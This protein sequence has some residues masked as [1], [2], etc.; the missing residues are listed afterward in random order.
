MLFTIRQS[1]EKCREQHGDLYII[2][3]DLMKAFNS[4]NRQGLWSIL[5]KI[6]CLGK[7]VK[8]IQSLH[9]GMKGQVAGG[10]E[11]SDFFSILNGTKHGCV[12]FIIFL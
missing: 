10:E 11:I 7:F 5:Q 1:Q 4:V 6:G 2:F 12:L 9:E 3:T 8:I